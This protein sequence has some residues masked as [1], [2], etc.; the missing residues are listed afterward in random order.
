MNSQ[1]IHISYLDKLTILITRLCTSLFPLFFLTIR[2]WTNICLF[3]ASLLSIIYVTVRHPKFYKNKNRTYWLLFIA[4]C[5]PFFTELLA[6]I[7]R[8]HIHPSSLD[9][10]LRFLLAAFVYIALCEIPSK[11]IHLNFQWVIPTSLL[12]CLVAYFLDPSTSQSWGDRAAT[13]FVD[14]ITF[15]S[16]IAALSFIC[17]TYL[18]NK[19]SLINVL[20]I[21]AFAASIYLV[22]M[23][24][25]RSAW[26]SCIVISLVIFL[27][28]SKYPKRNFIVYLFLIIIISLFAYQFSN[29]IKNRVDLISTE[30]IHYFNGDRDTSIGIR[31]SLARLDL[32][33]FYNNLLTGVEDGSLPTF[34]E[35]NQS[36]SYITE[37]LYH[38]KVNAGSHNELLAQISRKGVWGIISI[39]GLFVIPIRFFFKNLNNP[40]EKISSLAKAGFI[41]CTS[42]FISS[43]TIQVFNLKY[44]SSFYA[45]M[46]AV[47]SATII[48][49][50]LTHEQK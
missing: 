20:C 19:N 29:L 14:P 32:Y 27:I 30:I 16:Y 35:L 25:A 3:L 41:F 21:V 11:N 23:S 33:L 7:F 2:G 26:T 34:S 47:L 28:N 44:T 15:A 49:I 38:M 31:I 8:G 1:E 46:V 18:K 4:L 43:L 9:G 37:M 12:G 48:K 39:F 13:Y 22:I 42:I 40:I 10:P 24:Q 17:L 6:Q 36:Q 45:L 5:A 50:Q